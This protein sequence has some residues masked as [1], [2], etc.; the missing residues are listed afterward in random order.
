MIGWFIGSLGLIALSVIV[1]M[2]LDREIRKR[3]RK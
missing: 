3:W 2:E 1:G